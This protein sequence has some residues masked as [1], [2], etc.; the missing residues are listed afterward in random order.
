MNM[1]KLYGR[2]RVVLPLAPLGVPENSP[3]LERGDKMTLSGFKSCRDARTR[4]AI[5]SRCI[6]NPPQGAG[7]PPAEVAIM[8]AIETR[9]SFDDLTS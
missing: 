1:R 8:L 5:S 9:E 7:R 2:T 3:A 6:S 4:I